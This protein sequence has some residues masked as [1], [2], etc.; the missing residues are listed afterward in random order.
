MALAMA[1]SVSGEGVVWSS[2]VNGAG[3]HLGDVP[4]QNLRTGL[5]LNFISQAIYLIAI[6]AIKLTVGAMLLRIASIPF[7]K[8]L[9]KSLMVFMALWTTMCVMVRLS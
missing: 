7:Y 6:C 9:I 3:R 1:L 5:K 2:V 8:H 4:P